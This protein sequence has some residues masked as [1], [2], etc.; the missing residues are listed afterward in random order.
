MGAETEDFCSCSDSDDLERSTPSDAMISFE[1]LT[2][3][4]ESSET[5]P[6]A[7][8]ELVRVTEMSKMPEVPRGACFFLNV[9]LRFWVGYGWLRFG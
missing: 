7:Q 5:H 6:G 4:F 3:G 2:G 9:G 8:S 1:Y